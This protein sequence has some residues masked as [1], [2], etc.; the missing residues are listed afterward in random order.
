MYSL[1]VLAS[2]SFLL[3]LIL[4]PLCRNLSWRFGMVD[5]PDGLRRSTHLP[6]RE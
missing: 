3:A 2:V 5:R 6:C 4:T 1:A